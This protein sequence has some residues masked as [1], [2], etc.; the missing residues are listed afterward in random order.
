MTSLN[1]KR[2]A[3]FLM[4]FLVLIVDG[5]RFRAEAAS[6][7]RSESAGGLWAHNN[8]VAWMVTPPWD[9]KARGPEERVQMLEKLGFKNYAFMPHDKDILTYDAEIEALRR[10]GINL[11]AWRFYLDA[12]DPVAKATLETFKRHNVHPRL[13]VS[14]SL[15]GMNLPRPHGKMSAEEQHQLLMQLRRKDLTKAPQEL[16]VK[17][18]ADRINSLVKLAAP[19]GI[20]VALYNHNGWFGMM[21]NQV[22]IIERL[23]QLGVTDVGIV[24]NFS[25]ARDELHD[26]TLNFPELWKTIKPYVVTVNITGMQTDGDLV[27]PSQGDSEFDM[28]RT[29]ERSGWRGHVGLIA[30][31]GGDAEMTLRNYLV[32]LDWLAVELKHPGAGGPHPF[33]VVRDA[34]GR[35]S[36]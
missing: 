15:K 28:M 35:H 7:T 13:W 8:L 5:T 29:I 24:Y 32:G 18:E 1:Y 12:D 17:Q 6:R 2:L 20:K 10:H 30:E 16:R 3:A 19:Y 36:Y 33:P 34:S 23:K 25:H 21:D 11:L 31:K 26:D 4:A 9:A 14:Q 27:Y 22:A